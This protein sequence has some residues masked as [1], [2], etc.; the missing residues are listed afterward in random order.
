MTG[1]GVRRGWRPRR[2]DPD[3]ANRAI[4]ARCAAVNEMLADLRAVREGAMTLADV[5]RKW[6]IR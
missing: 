1:S 3:A 6:G 5:D 2:T 4:V